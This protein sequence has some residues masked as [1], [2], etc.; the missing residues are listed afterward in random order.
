M[1]RITPGLVLVVVAF[2]AA[3][4][5]AGFAIYLR[6]AAASR[7]SAGTMSAVNGPYIAG[8]VIAASLFNNRL[9]DIETEITNSADRSG[10]GGFL[11]SVRGIDGTLA[12]P[13]FS[14]T[15]ETGSGVW[16]NGAGDVRMSILGALRE[17][18]TTTGVAV[19]GTFS[20][21]D[22]IS[23][24]KSGTA[25]SVLAEFYEPSSANGAGLTL[26][27]GQAAAWNQTGS[28]TYT[29]NA[30]AANS[31]WCMGVAGN[32]STLCTDGNAKVYIGATGTGISAS[33]RGTVSWTP[34]SVSSGG[35][36]TTAITLTGAVAGA[37]CVP[38]APNGG[39]ILLK[40]GCWV[41]TNTCTL[42]LDNAWSA[43]LTGVSGT[44]ACR[45]LNP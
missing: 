6:P 2:F 27:V 37:D 9:S 35:E 36:V 13:A 10:R 21:T 24:S 8:Q 41:S 42:A 38:V 40:L 22:K 39:T 7:N 34:G 31:T 45:V 29:Q 4:L 14:W 30:T 16:R 11:A 19:T 15:S 33:Y 12:A 26:N 32:P 17:Q 43:A 5:G 18:W 1:K 3:A 44:Y 20:A 25:A 28:L 23:N